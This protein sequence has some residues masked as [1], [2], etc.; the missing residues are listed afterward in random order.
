MVAVVLKEC[1][2]KG[3]TWISPGNCVSQLA[4]GILG[5]PVSANEIL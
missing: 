4:T 2:D 5:G 1:V 3:L